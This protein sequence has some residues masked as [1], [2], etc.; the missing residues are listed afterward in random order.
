MCFSIPHIHWNCPFY[1]PFFGQSA[2]N[3]WVLKLPLCFAITH[4]HAHTSAVMPWRCV[5]S[6]RNGVH[7]VLVEQAVPRGERGRFVHVNVCV[8][9]CVGYIMFSRYALRIWAKMRPLQ[10]SEFV[11]GSM[12]VIVDESNG[13]G[14][15]LQQTQRNHHIHLPCQIIGAYITQK[16]N[17]FADSSV[18]N[19]DSG[20]R[21]LNLPAWSRDGECFSASTC[22][23][24]LK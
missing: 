23:R 11:W 15:S 1:K 21:C 24:R 7:G 5:V 20:L 22:G 13:D 16:W 6:V 9:V 10:F 18:W 3:K 12:M 8:H 17:T 2:Q 4:T 19:A 14:R